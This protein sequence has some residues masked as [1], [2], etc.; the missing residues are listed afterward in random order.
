M[1]MGKV[2][3]PS[4][5]GFLIRQVSSNKSLIKIVSIL[6]MKSHLHPASPPAP[7]N[8]EWIAVWRNPPNIVPAKPEDV[9]RPLRFPNS[10][11]VYQAP[12]I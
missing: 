11:S 10:R 3:R 6:T 2:M 8:P 5:Y 4:I 1:A 9:N 12:R 7:S